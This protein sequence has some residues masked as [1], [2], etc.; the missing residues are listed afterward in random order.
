[1]LAVPRIIQDGEEVDHVLAREMPEHIKGADLFPLVGWHWH[2]VGE[3]KDLHE[4]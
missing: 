2:T 1:M 4:S 3:E